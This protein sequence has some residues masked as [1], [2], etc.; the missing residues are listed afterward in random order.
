MP[1]EGAPPQGRQGGPGRGA[2]PNIDDRVSRLTKELKL[3]DDQQKQVRSVF[4]D[5]QAQ[6]MQLKKNSE[7]MDPAER[8]Q[9]MMAIHDASTEKIKAVL[10]DTQKKQYDQILQEQRQNMQEHKGGPGPN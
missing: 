10:N 5:Q 2:M 8:R 7:S 1:P 9:K 3:S 4:E 6:V